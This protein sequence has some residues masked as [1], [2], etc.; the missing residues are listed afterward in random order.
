[1]K[2]IFFAFAA[3][4]LVA[5]AAYAYPDDPTYDTWT[6]KSQNASLSKG[7]PVRVLKMVRYGNNVDIGAAIVSRD[8]LVYD[9][10]SDDGITVT[11]STVSADAHLAGIAV[12]A[13]QTADSTSTRAAD[14]WGRR[15]W[16]WAI[17]HGPAIVAVTAG[18]T[19]GN[20]VG[21]PWIPSADD[22]RATTVPT[23][24]RTTA[25]GAM[26]VARSKGGFFMD[27]AVAAD[28]AVEVFVNLE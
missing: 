8:V 6:N 3:F 16:G 23:Q 1:M 11:I 12:T 15:N 18:G 20:S 5:S 14:D 22:G 28:T 9:L 19:N 21:D 7:S 25:A 24:D 4:I 17:V 13:I 2:R 26:A 10:V 27:A